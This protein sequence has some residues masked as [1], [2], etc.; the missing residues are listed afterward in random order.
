M[1]EYSARSILKLHPFE[2]QY[3]LHPPN[4]RQPQQLFWNI[5]EGD[6]A[7]LALRQPYPAYKQS[8]S[9]AVATLHCGEIE[10]YAFAVGKELT[11]LL[12]ELGHSVEG[13][14]ASET[15]ATRIHL[16]KAGLAHFLEACL[17]RSAR[18]LMRL[19]RLP[20]RISLAKLER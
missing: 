11:P 18:V 20:S 19:S 13:E 9:G 12:N 4:P 15:K 7:T 5:E 3:L 17:L 2:S 8:K 6:L 10:F 1:T 14:G 16:F